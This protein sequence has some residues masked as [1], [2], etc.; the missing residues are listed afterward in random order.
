V[1]QLVHQDQGRLQR[2]RGVEVELGQLLA[3]VGHA[4][5]RQLRQAGQHGGGLGAAVGLD[6]ADQHRLPSACSA[7]GGGQ[8]GVGLAD[9]GRGAEVD[10]QLARAARRS[11]ACTC[12]SSASGSGRSGSE[13]KAM[14]G[15]YS[16]AR[17]RAPAPDSAPA[18]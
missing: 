6:H 14:R 17:L 2:Q 1:R 5:R 10:A 11:C 12:A 18:R 7:R 8:H 4:A 16:A 13:G 9:A 3:A 15:F